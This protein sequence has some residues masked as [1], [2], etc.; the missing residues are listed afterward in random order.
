MILKLDGLGLQL[1]ISQYALH[2]FTQTPFQLLILPIL[3]P[4]LQTV[5]NRLLLRLTLQIITPIA[6]IH[7]L[8]RIRAPQMLSLWSMVSPIILRTIVSQNFPRVS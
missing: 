8:S 7:T 3:E 1:E 5:S 6:E 4:D 2:L